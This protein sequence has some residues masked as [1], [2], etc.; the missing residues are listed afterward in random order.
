MKK[1]MIS[2]LLLISA[3]IASQAQDWSDIYN[4]YSGKDGVS[5]VYISPA[6]FKLMQKLPEVQVEDGEVDLTGI[7]RT[8]NGMYIL[9]I[10]DGETAAK[11]S[12]EIRE[13]FDGK[14]YEL[15]MEAQDG[16]EEMKI[17]IASKGDIVTDLIMFT[18]E[19]TSASLI[20]I[21]GEMPYSELQKL[22][23]E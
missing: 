4:R 7:I 12:G 13:K 18:A 23:A 10:E 1:L 3:A 9:D 20:A 16:P 6:M 8:F 2:A 21:T 17:F 15:L 11:L 22:I 19:K 14:K 5:S